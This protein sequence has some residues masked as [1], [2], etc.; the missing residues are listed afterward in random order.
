MILRPTRVGP[1]MMTL[2]GKPGEWE[3][4][5]PLIRA[6]E[7]ASGIPSPQDRYL[8]AETTTTGGICPMDAFGHL[9]IVEVWGGTRCPGTWQ[10]RLG[11]GTRNVLEAQGHQQGA[12]FSAGPIPDAHLE[13]KSW[14]PC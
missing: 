4:P 1:A 8:Q 2:G 11:A 6:Q 12:E 7:G 9:E 14:T 3:G 13:P 10:R 5:A